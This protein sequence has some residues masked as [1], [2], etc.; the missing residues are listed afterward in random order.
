MLAPASEHGDE[1]RLMIAIAAV[2]GHAHHLAGAEAG[3]SGALLVALFLAGLAGGTVHCAG[4]C[5]P[6]V[7]AQTAGRQAAVPGECLG[8]LTRITGALLLPYHLGRASTYALLGGVGAGLAA[9]IAE[10]PA[11]GWIRTALLM[12]AATLMAGAALEKGGLTLP[13]LAPRAMSQVAARLAR[14]LL[15]APF[16]PVRGYLLGA[17]LGLLPCGFLYGA[18][19]AAASAGDPL[20]GAAAMAAFALGTAPSLFAVALLGEAAGRR[21]RSSTTRLAPI[22]FAGNAVLLAWAAWL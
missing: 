20:T 16:G 1:S 5:G 12:L 11:L 22:A 6:F 18:L 17:A 14:P 2:T 19:A 21:W 9:G 10:Q 3:A 7:L 4:M 8:R 13:Q 15:E